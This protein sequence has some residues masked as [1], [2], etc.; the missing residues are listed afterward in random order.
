M[1]SSRRDLSA[2]SISP[3]PP[4]KNPRAF[5]KGNASSPSKSSRAWAARSARGPETGT[6]TPDSRGSARSA[7]NW[8]S[9]SFQMSSSLAFASSRSGPAAR[10][11]QSGRASE[12]GSPERAKAR[13]AA[14]LT[15][16]RWGPGGQ[17]T[18]ARIPRVLNSTVTCYNPIQS[19]LKRLFRSLV[20]FSADA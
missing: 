16:R 6:Y 13:A 7:E 3:R 10:T 4:R 11:M 20:A 5:S 15:S 9:M 17:R 1:I 19:R 8:P 18:R 2:A 12:E 14:R